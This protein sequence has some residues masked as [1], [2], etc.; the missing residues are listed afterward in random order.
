MEELDL[1]IDNYDYKDILNLFKIPINFGENHLK[2][3]KKKYY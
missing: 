3:A 1:N 2:Q